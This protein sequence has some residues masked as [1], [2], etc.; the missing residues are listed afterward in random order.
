MFDRS[1]LPPKWAGA[2]FESMLESLVEIAPFEGSPTDAIG[3]FT[4]SANACRMEL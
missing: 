4:W 1:G 3:D 2:S